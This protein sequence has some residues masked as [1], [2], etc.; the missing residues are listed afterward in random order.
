MQ[1]HI[2]KAYEFL[3]QHLPHDYSSGVQKILKKSNI[4]ASNFVVQNVRNG[5]TT[6]NTSILNAL[7]TV[8]KNAKKASEKLQKEFQK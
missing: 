2:K 7:L 4:V 1:P 6:S 3:N 8:A 5:K